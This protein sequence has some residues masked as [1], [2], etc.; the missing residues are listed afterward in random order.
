M[1]KNTKAAVTLQ[2]GIFISY[3]FAVNIGN[4]LIGELHK[5]SSRVEDWENRYKYERI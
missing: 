5:T 2:V 1:G 3:S 4:E